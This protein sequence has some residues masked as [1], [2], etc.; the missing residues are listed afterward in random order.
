MT[1][2][3]Y[4]LDG[5]TYSIP[6]PVKTASETITGRDSFYLAEALALATAVCERSDEPHKHG[7]V[8]ELR[9]L[10]DHHATDSEMNL[11]AA[12]SQLA[13]VGGGGTIGT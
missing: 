2:I 6:K 8:G 3:V 11:A 12:R 1:R 10:L 9:L 4:T 5:E 7:H 13:R